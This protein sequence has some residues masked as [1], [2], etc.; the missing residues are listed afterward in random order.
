M[1]IS[2]DAM[3][4]ARRGF[5]SILVAMRGRDGSEGTRDSGGL[6]IYDIYDA[7]E[8]IKAEPLFAG[9][10]DP[11]NL[12]ISGYSGGGGNVMS[13]LTKFPDYFNLGAAFFG[14]SDYGYDPRTGGIPTE[15]MSEETALRSSMRTSATRP[16]ETRWLPTNTT[17]GHPI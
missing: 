10:L 2:R 16:S 5:V 13:A 8:H 12:H 7:V 9:K 14:M 6:E 3:A 1:S 15:R 4:Q 11:T 17:P